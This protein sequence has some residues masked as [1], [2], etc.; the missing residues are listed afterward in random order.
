MTAL[1]SKHQDKTCPSVVYNTHIT[2]TLHLNGSHSD[3]TDSFFLSLNREIV[4]EL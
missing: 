4:K 1:H 2:S 3:K